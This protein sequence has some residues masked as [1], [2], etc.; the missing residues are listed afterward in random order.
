MNS[1]PARILV[2][3]DDP[4]I[5]ETLRFFLEKEGHEVTAADSGPAALRALAQEPHDLL[6]TDLRMPGMSGAELI[7]LTLERDPQV[8]CVLITAHGTIDSAIHVMK[9]GAY[10]YVQ[11]PLDLEA[12]S[13]VVARGVERRRLLTE[14]VAFRNAVLLHDLSLSVCA[15]LDLSAV[16]EQVLDAVVRELRTVHA[17]LL[18]RSDDGSFT[19]RGARGAAGEAPIGTVIAPEAC[20]AGQ[21]FET[22]ESILVRQ[23]DPWPG[24][25]SSAL[26]EDRYLS[27]LVV[28]LRARDRRVGVLG[29]G[30]DGPGRSFTPADE[31]SLAI[32][33]AHAAVAIE[34]ARLHDDLRR[35]YFQVVV[36]F[37]RAL[38]SRD[39]YLRGHSE[40]VALLAQFTARQMGLDERRCEVIYHGGL[41]HDLGKIGVSD[42]VLHKPA[43]LTEEEFNE[44]RLHPAIGREI[45]A[46]IPDLAP[47]AEII[48]TYHEKYDGSGYPNRLRGE[49]I[50][51]HSRI[52]AVAD[53]YDA[54]TSGRPYQTRMSF[55]AARARLKEQAGRMFDPQVVDAFLSLPPSVFEQMA[56][57]SGEERPPPA[58]TSPDPPLP[59]G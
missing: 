24:P 6:L 9:E 29:I 11:K 4:D 58:H 8:V 16:L 45:L 43:S 3:D 19:L 21:A 41:L 36:G 47:I 34:N 2:V 48:Y 37:S 12:L 1:N 22:G 13:L 27:S 46:P 26:G 7:R 18:L 44:I 49:Q 39:P 14:N 42:H 5:L 28:P 50:P 20:L 54:M 32:L 55:D 31:K 15:S 17:Y 51:L 25:R 33:A 56:A 40:R 59:A 30:M 52:V 53:A 35:R 10:D 23:S 38:E 57:A